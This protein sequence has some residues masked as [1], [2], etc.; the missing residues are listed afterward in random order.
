MTKT[1]IVAAE[2]SRAI[3]YA[4]DGI[5]APLIELKAFVH[6]ES[7]VPARSLISDYAGSSFDGKS[8]PGIHAV[9]TDFSVKEHEANIFSK[10]LADFLE[11]HRNNNSY[12]YLVIMA[13][14]NFLGLLREKFSSSLKSLIIHEVNNNLVKASPTLIQKYL[15][16]H[17][18]L[19]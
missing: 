16:R 19:S 14:P 9:G 8:L 6:P 12:K 10:D 1:W 2:S 17:L 7:R 13:A 15:P 4:A 5:N 18:P 3:I 11:K